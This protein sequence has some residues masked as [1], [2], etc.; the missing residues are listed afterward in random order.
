MSH[1]NLPAIYPK[2]DDLEV[3]S[4][5]RR[6]GSATVSLDGKMG[7]ILIYKGAYELLREGSENEIE[8]IQV[9]C[10]PK[11]PKCFWIVPSAKSDK[12]SRPL[13]KNGGVR[14]LS[15]KYLTTKLG[16]TNKDRIRCN[17]HPDPVNGGLV[18]DTSVKIR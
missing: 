9:K 14:C 5:R 10:S 16:L 2:L 12:G 17:A 15:L 7:R 18:I 13:S 1:S 4:D 11:Y 3:V 8:T 6:R